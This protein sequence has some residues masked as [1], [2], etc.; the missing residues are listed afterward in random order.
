MP[1][2]DVSSWKPFPFL[3]RDFFLK[4]DT[5]LTKCLFTFLVTVPSRGARGPQRDTCRSLVICRFP[6]RGADFAEM[7]QPVKAGLL[8]RWM[9]RREP[10]PSSAAA[11]QSHCCGTAEGQ[12]AVRTGCAEGSASA[13]VAQ[14]AAGEG[15]RQ[16]RDALRKRATT[17]RCCLC[18]GPKEDWKPSTSCRMS[19]LCRGRG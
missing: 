14:N 1:A 12:V 18:R 16:D 17:S 10:A 4:H 11:T 6:S 3:R 8:K 2:E 9:G 13:E 19:T 15:L 7:A 5:D